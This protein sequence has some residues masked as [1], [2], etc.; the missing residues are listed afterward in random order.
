MSPSLLGIGGTVLAGHAGGGPA[1]R[2]RSG[3]LSGQPG[4]TP[5]RRAAAD[6]AARAGHGSI[7]VQAR[8]ALAALAVLALCCVLEGWGL[9]VLVKAGRVST[10]A[11]LPAAARCAA[12]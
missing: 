10:H 8:A 9:A 1:V 3:T 2:H 7:A 12:P 6:A 5:R 4:G 11:L